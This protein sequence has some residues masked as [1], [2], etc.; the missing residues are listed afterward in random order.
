MGE[1]TSFNRNQ[2]ITE[3]KHVRQL[4]T[5]QEKLHK[6]RPAIV[7]QKMVFCF[8]FSSRQSR[9]V[10]K[11]FHIIFRRELDIELR[12][13]SGNLSMAYSQ[14]K[15]TF[16][17]LKDKKKTWKHLFFFCTLHSIPHQTKGIE[18]KFSN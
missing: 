7:N 15:F 12:L 13:P 14:Q 4:Q 17:R 18:N 2:T 10:E 8:S 5:A 11:S 6:N 9:I 16:Y 3:E 1:T